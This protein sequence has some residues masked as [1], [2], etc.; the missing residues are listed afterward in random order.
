MQQ[1]TKFQSKQSNERALAVQPSPDPRVSL[2]ESV[3]EDLEAMMDDVR[4]LEDEVL[5][6]V[7]TAFRAGNSEDL[8]AMQPALRRLADLRSW[9][10]SAQAELEALTA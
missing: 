1:P 5:A 7:V 4:E 6:L 10:Q 9:V 8:A 2:A 3:E